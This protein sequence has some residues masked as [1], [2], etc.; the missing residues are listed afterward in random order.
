METDDSETVLSTS[1]TSHTGFTVGGV[2]RPI[3]L[4]LDFPLSR[5]MFVQPLEVGK[6]GRY[7]ERHLLR[8]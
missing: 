1:Y 5:Y 7:F 6:E 2:I 3:V 8:G 4:R